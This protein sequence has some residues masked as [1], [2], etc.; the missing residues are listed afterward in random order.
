M[1]RELFDETLADRFDVAD[2]RMGRELRDH[3]KRQIVLL[4]PQLQQ[5]GPVRLQHRTPVSAGRQ[6][7][8]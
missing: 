1:R 4:A 2:A 7:R 6:S 5:P 8:R 3:I